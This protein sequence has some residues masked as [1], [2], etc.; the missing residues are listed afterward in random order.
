MNDAEMDAAFRDEND[1]VHYTVSA[2]TQIETPKPA[3]QQEVAEAAK[4][5]PAEESGPEIVDPLSD[6]STTKKAPWY[7][8]E[9]EV[10][11]NDTKYMAKAG[12]LVEGLTRKINALEALL[13]CL[14]GAA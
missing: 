2:M 1:F 6:L 3:G 8:V 14:R 13:K 10:V 12:P 11:Y 5:D 9:V 4:D 7:G